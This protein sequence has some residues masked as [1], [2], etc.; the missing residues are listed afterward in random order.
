MSS[1]DCSL[2]VLLRSRVFVCGQECLLRTCYKQAG[3]STHC[4][5]LKITML[6]SS[7]RSNQVFLLNNSVTCSFFFFL[8]IVLYYLKKNYLYIFG[9]AGSLLLLGLFSSCVEWGRFSSCSARA[10]PCCGFSCCRAWALRCVSSVVMVHGLSCPVACGIF[11][12][13]RW[14]PSPQHW[15]ADY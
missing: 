14:N 12:D 10:F 5:L 2:R 15:Q 4:S 3:V 13:Q 9:C 8:Y 7:V 1:G 11:P 6:P